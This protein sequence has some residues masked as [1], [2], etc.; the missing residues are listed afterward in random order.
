MKVHLQS[1]KAQK[2]F[3]FDKA[4]SWARFQPP[5]SI[6]RTSAILGPSPEGGGTEDWAES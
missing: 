6:C 1:R 2:K 3:S 4:S 5:V